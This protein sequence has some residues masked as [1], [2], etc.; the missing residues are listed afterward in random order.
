MGKGKSEALRA[1]KL[2][3]LEN[4]DAI[5]N[6]PYYWAA[7]SIIGDSKPIEENG[8]YKN[9]WHW[10]II[11]IFLYNLFIYSRNKLSFTSS[12]ESKSI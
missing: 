9:H 2:E 1:A 3:Y 5:T 7:F 8:F 10:L 6:H 4:G 11:A 12:N